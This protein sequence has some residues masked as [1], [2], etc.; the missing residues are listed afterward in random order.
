MAINDPA[1]P[2]K[3]D[4]VII[5]KSYNPVTSEGIISNTKITKMASQKKGVELRCVNFVPS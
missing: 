2:G 5:K 3:T 4:K 1:R